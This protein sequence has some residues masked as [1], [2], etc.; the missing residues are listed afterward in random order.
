MKPFENIVEKGENAAYQHFL[1]FPQ[2]FLPFPK[3]ISNFSVTFTLSSVNAF[4]LVQSE[5]LSFGSFLDQILHVEDRK[6]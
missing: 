6:F 2:Y 4:N 1:L 3:Q 5:N